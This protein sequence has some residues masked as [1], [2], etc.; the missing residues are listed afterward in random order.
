MPCGAFVVSL[1]DVPLQS[2][3]PE[4]KAAWLPCATNGRFGADGTEDSAHWTKGL[5][6]HADRILKNGKLRNHSI[7]TAGTGPNRPVPTSVDGEAKA[8]SS[9]RTESDRCARGEAHRQATGLALGGEGSG[10]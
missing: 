5:R 10:V 1:Y 2:N 9:T 6:S 3:V 8:N 4:A 7:R